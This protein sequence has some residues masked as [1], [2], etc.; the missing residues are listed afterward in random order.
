MN[1]LEI[2]IDVLEKSLKKN[3][4]KPITISHLLNIAKMVDKIEARQN[5]VEEDYF[6]NIGIDI[7]NGG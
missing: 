4:D 1:R 3:G 2:F 6:G 7:Y 5:S